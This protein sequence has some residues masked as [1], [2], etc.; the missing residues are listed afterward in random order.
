MNFIEWLSIQWK[1]IMSLNKDTRNHIVMFL[2]GTS[3]IVGIVFYSIIGLF[4]NPSA[5]S[6]PEK[7]PIK[8]GMAREKEIEKEIE[9]I[10]GEDIAERKIIKKSERKAKKPTSALKSKHYKTLTDVEYVKMFAPIAIREM[11]RSGVPASIT[12]AQ[13]LVESRNGNSELAKETDNHFG[14]KC[15]I[16]GCRNNKH[17]ANFADDVPWDRFRRYSSVEE[18]YR[19]HSDFLRGDKNHRRYQHLF[20]YGKD[21]RRWA[22]GLKSSGYATNINYPSILIDRVVRL[23]LYQYDRQ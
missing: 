23:K 11:H 5:T 12:L 19:A 4:A 16:K 10:I 13:G 15:G 9:R 3:L 6:S 7:E 21:W 20:K 18:C 1:M 22:Y 17:C 8:S 2:G 14:I